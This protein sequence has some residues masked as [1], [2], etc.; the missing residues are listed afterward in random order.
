MYD[1]NDEQKEN[2]LR[3]YSSVEEYILIDIRRRRNYECFEI[4]NRGQLWYELNVNTEEKKQEFKIW[5]EEWLQA[6]ETKKIP[7]KPKW[8]N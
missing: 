8:L 7:E 3:V 4:I 1:F 5:Y 2:I 6:T